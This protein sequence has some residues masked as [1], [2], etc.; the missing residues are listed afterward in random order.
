MRCRRA[1]TELIVE[2]A[3]LAWLEELDFHDVV[4]ERRLLA[5]LARSCPVYNRKTF[6]T[7]SP[8]WLMTLMQILPEAGRGNGRDSVV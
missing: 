3:A 4:L 7:S 8:K 1:F 5:A 2:E 6:C